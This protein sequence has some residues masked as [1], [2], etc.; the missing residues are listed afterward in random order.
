MAHV[1]GL[2]NTKNRHEAAGRSRLNNVQRAEFEY[3]SPMD[4]QFELCYEVEPIDYIWNAAEVL[5]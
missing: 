1:S 3:L 5:A 4:L 2:A